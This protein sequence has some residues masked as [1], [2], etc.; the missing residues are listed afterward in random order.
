M[1][2]IEKYTGITSSNPIIINNNNFSITKDAVNIVFKISNYYR[3]RFLFIKDFMVN[4][5]FGEFLFNR[6]LNKKINKKKKKK[7]K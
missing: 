7:K 5:K 3:F 4:H 2:D 1:L 6:K